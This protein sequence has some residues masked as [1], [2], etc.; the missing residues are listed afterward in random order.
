MGS[1]SGGWLVEVEAVGEEAASGEAAVDGVAGRVEAN[2]ASEADESIVSSWLS[3]EGPECGLG[4]GASDHLFVRSRRRSRRELRLWP[5]PQDI[6]AHL[7]LSP[8]V[9]S[10]V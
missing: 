9:P 3:V 6:Y 10:T 4:G 1:V 8:L 7:S 5:S 2:R